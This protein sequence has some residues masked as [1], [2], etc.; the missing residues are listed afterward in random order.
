MATVK[1]N[2]MLNYEDLAGV[3]IVNISNKGVAT[4][5]SAGEQVTLKGV[6][7]IYSEDLDDLADIVNIAQTRIHGN[8]LELLLNNDVLVI[9]EDYFKNNG[10]S[11]FKY[12]VGSND[13]VFNLIDEA[14]ID[15][16][17]LYNEYNL[18]VAHDTEEGLITTSK[19]TGTDF[20]D[21][22]D[23]S[24]FSK[25]QLKDA[26]G[27]ALKNITI[28][29]G[30]GNDDITGSVIDDVITGGVGTNN[31]Y[32]E[33]AIIEDED[34]T[35]GLAF[36]DDT[37][38]LT[39]GETLN[40]LLTDDGT[41]DVNTVDYVVD[42]NDVI[43]T[44]TYLADAG[45][46]G[47]EDDVY[48][49]SSVTL[50]NYAKDASAKVYVGETELSTL[51][52]HDV[53]LS[54]SNAKFTST[55]LGSDIAV[56]EETE[57]AL[58]VDLSAS[59]F[60]NIVDLEN[61]EGKVTVK[62]GTKNDVVTDNAGDGV[63]TL[64]TGS[65]TLTYTDGN[66]IVN[67]T[68][69]ESL[70]VTMADAQLAV[71]KNDVVATT[72]DGSIT[73]KNFAARDLGATVTVNENNLETYTY[74]TTW[75]DAEDSK[76]TSKTKS[77]TGSRLKD[78]VDASDFVVTQKIGSST[79]PI[80]PV[81]EPEEFTMPKPKRSDYE[82]K[83][84]YD[85]ALEE[86]NDALAEYKADLKDYNTYVNTKGV[87]VD[88]KDGANKFE[89]SVYADTAKAGA[90]ND[91]II[92]SYGK[93]VYTLGKGTNTADY[94]D[95]D[96]TGV[97]TFNLTNGE[98][99]VLTNLDEDAS[100]SKVGND[101]IV[102]T[103]D[104]DIILKN[105]A[106]NKTGADVYVGSVNDANE[107][108]DQDI[109]IAATGASTQGTFG[110]DKIISDKA[111]NTFVESYTA[112]RGFGLDNEITSTNKKADTIQITTTDKNADKLSAYDLDFGYEDSVVTV[113]AGSLGKIEYTGDLTKGLN[114]VDATGTKWAFYNDTVA[115]GEEPDEDVNYAD[116][117]KA[118]TNV[119]AQIDEAGATILDSK[120]NDI[121]IGASNA[122]QKFT[123]TAGMDMYNGGT[124]N[125]TYTVASMDK[126]TALTINDL[127]G[128]NDKLVFSPNGNISPANLKNMT[129]FFDVTNGGK[130][131]DDSL[132]FINDS[133]LSNTKSLSALFNGT[134]KGAVVLDNYFVENQTVANHGVGYIENVQFAGQ[135]SATSLD[136]KVT[137]IAASVVE[138]LTSNANYDSAMDVIEAGNTADIQSLML[139]YQ[140]ASVG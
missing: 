10:K 67:L 20:N 125:D 80:A 59:T 48:A 104:K 113:D 99:L 132:M 95:T 118:K 79:L 63:Y 115:K 43:I 45:E 75:S 134:G 120:K 65:N 35:D 97:D 5:T 66:D 131:G 71:V 53:L 100:Y 103:N 76:L 58:T 107:I 106:S 94:T 47:E 7:G 91:T 128:S 122:G 139:C 86:Y 137:A 23:L 16:N 46:E 40:V 93:D 96:I 34:V 17:N 56:A 68:N 19:I 72:E 39:R 55:R 84:A 49:T 82:T 133:V 123:Y 30:A 28:N 8:N 9:V 11:S 26:K 102:E 126:N 138:W 37:Y 136:T 33:N 6:T 77:F 135:S 127:G 105:Y 54:D 87:T 73:F 32:V 21:T 18:V 129:I 109:I 31:L 108:W 121:I 36:G 22:F 116:L 52:R 88:L 14:I 25:D 83:E 2:T 114:L 24:D 117:S 15:N 62:G 61:A 38:N 98:K 13:D 111:S 81:E 50:K 89:G 124:G 27:N 57:K 74:K 44:S 112:E 12:I 90:G 119:I 78:D 41:N 42:K 60:N 3:G 140:T 92:A 85:A 1:T 69:E 130:A 70:A 64:G 110:N 29:A 4:Y 51:A 101:I